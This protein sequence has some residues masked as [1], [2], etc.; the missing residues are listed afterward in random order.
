MTLPSCSKDGAFSPN[1]M[2]FSDSNAKHMLERL[3]YQRTTGRFNKFIF[4]KINF[5]HF[6]FCDACI[7]VKDRQ[8][9]AHRMVLAAHSPYFDSILRH[10]KIAKEKVRHRKKIN[11]EFTD[12]KTCLKLI[13]LISDCGKLPRADSVRTNTQL[14]VQWKCDNRSSCGC[15]TFETRQQFAGNQK[16]LFLDVIFSDD[17]PKKLLCWLFDALHWCGQL[18]GNSGVVQSL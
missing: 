2:T 18:L 8:F 11:F 14:Y 3:R 17:S 7:F 9:I 1:P 13:I 16:N 10:N 15:W 4:S 12:R 5:F 6:R